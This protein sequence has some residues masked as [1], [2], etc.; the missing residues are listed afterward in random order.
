VQRPPSGYEPGAS[1]KELSAIKGNTCFL[2]KRKSFEAVEK[3]N[4]AA[5]SEQSGLPLGTMGTVIQ[6]LVETNYQIW[7]V[8]ITDCLLREGLWDLTTRTQTVIVV[9][10]AED[11][12]YETQHEKYLAQ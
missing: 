11:T 7:A 4:P 10:L 6:K 8:G 12:D 3:K 1:E 9:P 2:S 5:M